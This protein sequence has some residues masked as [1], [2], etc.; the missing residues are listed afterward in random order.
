[1]K[2]RILI[3]LLAA[4]LSTPAIAAPRMFD[5]PSPDSPVHRS[6][7]AVFVLIGLALQ[8]YKRM[9]NK[10]TIASERRA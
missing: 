8:T 7:I 6:A 2:T 9:P 5:V 10:Q 1:M 4:C 3:G